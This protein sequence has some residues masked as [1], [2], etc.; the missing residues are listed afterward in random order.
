MAPAEL[1]VDWLTILPNGNSLPVLVEPQIMTPITRDCGESLVDVSS[2]FACLEAY[3]RAGWK[4][5]CSGTH[6]REGVVRRLSNV[7]SALPDSFGLVLFDGWRPLELQKELFEAAY[8]DSTLPEGF[9][10][11]PN[12]D[13]TVPPPHVSGGTVDLTLSYN[14]VALELGTTFDSFVNDAA[15]AAFESVDSPVRRLRRLLCEAMWAQ[16]F[17]VYSGEW[18]HFEYGTSRWASIRHCEG[19]YQRAVLV[20]DPQA[21]QDL[22]TL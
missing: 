1:D 17:I 6:L 10:A 12:E 11:P 5:S 9:L 16:D 15:T 18:W 20:E 3:R 8:R 2:K 19:L 22:L 13:E 7:E 21:P 4:N 14:G